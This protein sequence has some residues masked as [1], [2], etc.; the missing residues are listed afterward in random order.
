MAEPTNEAP[1]TTA[2]PEGTTAAP[3]QGT[4]IA[5]MKAE[6]E[7]LLKHKGELEADLQKYRKRNEADAQKAKEAGDFAKLLEIE[8]EA[9]AGLEAQLRDLS[10]FA[11]IG[12]LTADKA[13]KE[14]EEAKADTTI[15]GYVRKALE[16]ARSP[17]DAADILREF[18]SVSAQ[19]APQKPVTIAPAQG[20]P[21]AASPSKTLA[22]MTPEEIINASDDQLSKVLGKQGSAEKGFFS[23][24]IPQ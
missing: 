6:L 12:K 4:E 7:R 16:A 13:A 24:F 1:A 2:A 3:V 23:R 11:E 19:A 18:R 10:G 5:T 15:P 20:A 17:I 21:P 9:R 8:K 22:Q 14:I